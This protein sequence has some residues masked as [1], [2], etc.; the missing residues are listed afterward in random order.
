MPPPAPYYPG[1]AGFHAGPPRG[2][3]VGVASSVVGGIAVVCSLVAAVVTV[4]AGG[5]SGHG[6]PTTGDWMLG[7]GMLAGCGGGAV[8]GVVA[9][10]LGIV[11]VSLPNR[12]KGAAVAGLVLGGAALGLIGLAMAVA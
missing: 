2:S 4:A 1:A 11:G 7:L 9:L 3:G 10:V 12:R 6:Q 5:R 8:L